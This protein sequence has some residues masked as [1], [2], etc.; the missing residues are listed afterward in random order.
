M[1]QE[2]KGDKNTLIAMLLM[3]ALLMGYFY[4]NKPSEEELRDRQKQEQIVDQMVN[5]EKDTAALVQNQTQQTVNP[6]DSLAGPT[7]I[8]AKDFSAENEKF[9][10]K[11]SGKG[12][13]ITELELVEYTAFSEFAEDHRQ[14]LFLINDGNNKFNLKFKDTS[15]REINT[16][17]LS[18]VPS[19]KEADSQTIVSMVAPINGGKLE[20]VYTLGTDYSIGFEVKSEGIQQITN[21]KE[22]G[23]TWDLKA[24]SLEK[25]KQQEGY[26]AQTYY[27]FKGTSDVEY[28][29]FGA[30][31]WTEKKD[32]DWIAFKQQFFASILS[33]DEGFQ[34]PN[35]GSEIIDKDIDPKHS[36]DYYFSAVLPVSGNELNYKMQWDFVPLDYKLLAY[37][38][39]E[40][41]DFGKIIPFGWGFLG[42][43]NRNFFLLIF[44]W[45][46]KT[47]VAYGWVILLMT[48][49]VKLVLSPVMY[50]QYKQSA[51]MRILR[52]ELN[53]INEAYAGKD[54]AVKRQ[55]KTMELYRKAGANPLSGC[56][57]ALIQIPIFYA[58]FRFFPNVI[59]LRG[60][61]FLWAE[62]LTA[63]DSPVTLPD[64]VPFMDGHLSVFALSYIIAMVV[65]FRISGSM[66]S[67][68][69]PPQEGMPDMRIMKY[70]MYVMPLFF[71]VFLNNYASGLSWY[72]L[73]SNVINIGIILIIKNVLIDDKKIHANIQKNKAAPKKQ[74]KWGAKMSELMEQAQEQKK[75]QEAKKSQTTKKNYKKK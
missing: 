74:S 62:D 15:G 29:L 26:W 64:W 73:V 66:D 47:G 4:L 14:A 68:N 55:Q 71:F 25:G 72:Y 17:D 58:L 21:E 43:L 7:V 3:G 8:E 51:M 75:L 67:F 39:Y 33:F 49:V 52:P 56:L 44:Q 5:P 11:F 48:I 12:G 59:D 35:G 32:I 23:L 41:T 40:E 69:Q 63:F 28:E 6:E 34:A 22:I 65:Y 10:V 50:K 24:S 38:Q 60:K 16:A 45:L 1:Q 54:N 13:Y 30:D 70:M 31:K 53:E 46:A 42:W 18:F 36:R 61:S 19:V 27:R 37:D 57:P 2:K 9:K 20:Y